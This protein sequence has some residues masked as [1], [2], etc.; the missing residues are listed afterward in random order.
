MG[1]RSLRK[2][3]VSFLVVLLLCLGLVPVLA[4]TLCVAASTPTEKIT[5]APFVHITDSTVNELR[6][7]IGYVDSVVTI[8]NGAITGTYTNT[9]E[10][11]NTVPST[12][13]LRWIS[14]YGSS[15]ITINNTA[16]LSSVYLYVYGSSQL[17]IIN[18]TLSAVYTYD[19][20]VLTVNNSTISVIQ[21]YDNSKVYLSQST[22]FT[23]FPSLRASVNGNNCTINSLTTQDF[24]TINITNNSKIE[25][26]TASDFSTGQITNCNIT[27][28][29]SVDAANILVDNSSITNK[30]E[31]GIVCTTGSLIIDGSTITGLENCRNTTTLTNGNYPSTWDLQTVCALASSNVNITNNNTLQRISGYGSSTVYLENTTFDSLLCS[32]YSNVVY[33]NS[34]GSMIYITAEKYSSL[35]LQNV[36]STMASYISVHDDASATIKN[37]N[38]SIYGIGMSI[39]MQDQST[40]DLENVNL[41]GGGLGGFS[42]NSYDFSVVDIVNVQSNGWPMTTFF[43]YDLSVMNISSSGI[44]YVYYAVRSTGDMAVTDDV[45]SG[46]YIN[47]TIWDTTPVNPPTLNSIAVVDTHTATIYGSLSASVFLHDKANL[48]T[49]NSTLSE[50]VVLLDFS[51]LS[52]TNT[53]FWDVEMY[54]Q[55]NAILSNITADSFLICDSASLTCTGSTSAPTTIGGIE[56]ISNYPHMVNVVIQNCTVTGTIEANTWIIQPTGLGYAI[57]LLFYY[58]YSSSQNQGFFTLSLTGVIVAAIV[59]VAGAIL[60]RRRA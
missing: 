17:T 52:G 13:K 58:Y 21:A 23:V 55:S 35:N 24:S 45:P 37:S 25:Y 8:D 14:I 34:Q 39:S 50:D 29:K 47:T 16:N 22:I 57:P 46:S 44:T 1:Y 6:Y 41:T 56:A 51:T 33:K 12:H 30:V 4:G 53:T 20:S 19:S 26:F 60:W 2:I 27:D 18:S 43:G 3:L 48:N 36:N 49:Q 40:L 15:R 38:M 28:F 10:T 9:T 7:G 42:V 5:L 32:D 54:N 31:Y 11:L 59:A